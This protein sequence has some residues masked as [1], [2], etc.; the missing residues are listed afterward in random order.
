LSSPEQYADNMRLWESVKVTDPKFHKAVAYGK[1]RFTAID[2]Q[3]QLQEATKRWGPYG[4]KWGLR[5]IQHE[6]V[7]MDDIGTDGPVV[8]YAIILRAEFFY[9]FNDEEVSFE[10][11]NDDK[12]ARGQEVLKKLI[13]NTRSKALS[14]LGFSADVFMGMYDDV[15]YVK[16]LEKRFGDQNV[17][18]T[19]ILAVVKSTMKLDEL[20]KHKQRIQKMVA[21]ETIEDSEMAN[22][23]LSAVAEREKELRK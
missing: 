16:D 22:K 20:A 11:L 14:L 3:W 17:L 12:F 21:D 13:T 8:D 23:L 4:H 10:I 7:R 6:I 19:S 2:P 18:V 1:R 5:K 9:P 15:S